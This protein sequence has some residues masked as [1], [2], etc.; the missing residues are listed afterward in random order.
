MTDPK[1]NSGGGA[2]ID[3]GCPQNSDALPLS[4]AQLG[5]WFAQKINPSSSAY[6]I[7]EY[8]EIHGAIDPA[9]FERALRQVVSEAE[10]LRVQIAEQAG[11][12]QQIVTAGC[13]WSLPIIDLG[14]ESDPRAAAEA[15][16][17]AE[18]AQSIEPMRGPLFAFALFK[19][20]P[21]RLFWYA[22]YHHLVMDGFGMWLVARRVA[23]IYTQLSIAADVQDRVFGSLAASLEED[24]AYRASEQFT[25]D[26]QYWID[27]L[28][29]WP[30]PG[31]LSLSGRPSAKPNGFIRK[32]T[33]LQPSTVDELRSL[34]RRTGTSLARIM[35]AAAAIFLH[36]VTGMEDVAFG[37]PVA[38]RSD[39]TRSIPGMA[40]NVVPLRLAVRPGMTVLEVIEQTS[41]ELRWALEHQRYQLA[42]L[43]RDVG[44]SVGDRTLFG[45][46][47]N[48]MPFNYDFSFAGNRAIAHNLSL[49][50]VED[51]SISV[52][53][54][55]DGGPFR[56]DFD[57]N[58]ALHAAADL[59]G[60]QQR[61]LRLLTG[62]LDPSLVIG[63]LEI[64]AAGERDTILRLWN[65]TS[66]PLS[67]A[68]A[69]PTLPA[70]FAAQAARTPEATAL[71]FEDRSLSYAALA[72]HANR[73]AHH[74]RGLG[75]GPE[76]VVGLCVERSPE[77]VI[78]LMGIL[79]AGGAYL[80]LDPQYPAERL[81]FMLRDA[82]A[83]VLVTQSGLLGRLPKDAVEDL[84]GDAAAAGGTGA[85]LVRLDADWPAIARQPETAPEPALD[86]RH[87]A[88]VI[89]TSGSTGTP[90]GVVV[91]HASLVNKIWTLGT[92]FGAGPDFRS[93]L[94]ISCAFDA[95][96]EQ[97]LLPL[98]GGGT[99]VVI[100]DEVREVPPSILAGGD[101][102][103]RH[104]YKLRSILS[105]SR[106]FVMF[107]RHYLWI[108]W[109]SAVRHSRSSFRRR[110]CVT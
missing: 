73:L 91:E 67:G 5:I 109:R 22:R 28:A 41:L 107:R 7:G 14:A 87:P 58:P 51:L 71:V 88:Y 10:I 2:T 19:A 38:A 103:W 59:S 52:Y 13:G 37:A 106:L 72:A 64:L 29:A 35:G 12:P 78:G 1:C 46:S 56:I 96:L 68:G 81:A 102:W 86:P 30:E 90:K 97:T 110:F 55:S 33:Y 61:Y 104:F 92:E 79:A 94:I 8:L 20:S 98:I 3:T 36:R 48:V 40:S 42:D 105:G 25:Q 45:L 24:A 77:M 95:S 47:V 44:G 11:E 100:S 9:L 108:I 83:A 84:T 66:R 53:D 60:Y 65:D 27:R 93:A 63:S 17:K 26:R 76:T 99:A 57:T 4:S 50:P 49:G 21:T 75:V 82:G 62:M 69:L 32:T 54:R 18:L 31:S 34:A 15:W 43:R 80:P 6:N 101:P 16:M 85:R 39:V 23:D 70:L 74:L 89:Y